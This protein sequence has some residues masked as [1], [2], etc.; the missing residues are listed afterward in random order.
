MSHTFTKTHNPIPKQHTFCETQTSINSQTAYLSRG[1][2]STAAIWFPC[3]HKNEEFIHSED[4][5]E[6][7]SGISPWD[8]SQYI[9]RSLD[10]KFQPPFFIKQCKV[11]CKFQPPSL[12]S[13]REGIIFFYSNKHLFSSQQKCYFFIPNWSIL[14]KLTWFRRLCR[15][16]I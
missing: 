15:V 5:K 4:E 8:D 12:H 2:C 16:L 10:T 7:N 1:P 9:A 3:I 6:G 14:D 13:K 11:S